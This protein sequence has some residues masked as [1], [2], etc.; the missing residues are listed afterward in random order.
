MASGQQAAIR[1][2]QDLGPRADDDTDCPTFIYDRSV[3][4][5]RAQH[6]DEQK[7]DNRQEHHSLFGFKV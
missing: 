4:D 2:Q 6:E 7:Q 3:G 1:L 5:P